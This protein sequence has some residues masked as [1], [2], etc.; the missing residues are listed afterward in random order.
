MVGVS[1][2]RRVCPVQKSVVFLDRFLSLAKT[3]S[4]RDSLPLASNVMIV[5]APPRFS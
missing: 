4:M 3:Y 2:L 5:L 1:A